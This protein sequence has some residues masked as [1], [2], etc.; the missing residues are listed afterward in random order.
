MHCG[1]KTMVGADLSI[2]FSRGV[3]SSSMGRDLSSNNSETEIPCRGIEKLVP[4]RVP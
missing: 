1:F 2:K 3:R 4:A